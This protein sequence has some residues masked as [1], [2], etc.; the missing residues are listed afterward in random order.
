MHF[1]KE[2]VKTPPNPDG[3]VHV[4]D[5]ESKKNTAGIPVKGLVEAKLVP[6]CDRLTE[7]DWCLILTLSLVQMFI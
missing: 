2:H 4:Q 3:I 1:F 5:T 6:L 7:W